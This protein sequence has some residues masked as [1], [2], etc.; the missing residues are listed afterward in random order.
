MGYRVKRENG[1]MYFTEI[2]ALTVELF[3]WILNLEEGPTKQMWNF[4]G[5][6]Q[7]KVT[8]SSPS[9]WSFSSINH[10][11]LDTSMNSW[12]QSLPCSEEVYWFLGAF[13]IHDRDQKVF[14]HLHRFYSSLCVCVTC[15][16]RRKACQVYQPESL[17]ITWKSC[18]LFKEK[19][20]VSDAFDL[21]K[22]Q[23]CLCVQWRW[24]TIQITQMNSLKLWRV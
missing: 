7:D 22:R 18:F 1:P 2:S 10:D 24:V 12:K 13:A 14:S 4:A 20:L 8:Y 3:W 23:P 15:V 11:H 5:I 16:R 19:P 21:G 17:Q 6:S 9:W